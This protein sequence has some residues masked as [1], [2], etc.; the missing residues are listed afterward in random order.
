MLDSP[1]E[2]FKGVRCRALF[3]WFLWVVAVGDIVE[4][5]GLGRA[6]GCGSVPEWWWD[7]QGARF[8]LADNDRPCLVTVLVIDPDFEVSEESDPEIGLQGVAMPGFDDS[9]VLNG[10]VDLA[11]VAHDRLELVHHGPASVVCEVLRWNE[12]GG[13]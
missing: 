6:N 1:G 13:V 2:S 12:H 5:A 7:D 11:L 9:W 3:I 10:E 4:Q 8:F